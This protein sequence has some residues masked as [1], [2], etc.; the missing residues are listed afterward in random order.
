MITKF[1][2][3]LETAEARKLLDPAFLDRLTKSGTKPDTLNQLMRFARENWPDHFPADFREDSGTPFGRE[4]VR[5]FWAAYLEWVA[6]TVGSAQKAG[7]KAVA[8]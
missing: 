8:S 6:N 1:W 7:P 5:Q 4:A 3:F 2:A